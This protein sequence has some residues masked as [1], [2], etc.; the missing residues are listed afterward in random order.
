MKKLALALGALSLVAGSA[1]PAFASPC[2]D[3][4]GRFVKCPAK[5]KLCRDAKGHFVK[6]RKKG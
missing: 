6:C 2:K 5:P 3:A 4:K 1:T